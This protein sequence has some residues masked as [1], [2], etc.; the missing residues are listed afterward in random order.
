MKS[1]ERKEQLA[2]LT[3]E[4]CKN[5]SILTC[6]TDGVLVVNRQ[7]QVVLSNA[8]AARIF[9]V[10]SAVFLPADVQDIIKNPTLLQFHDEIAA[11]DDDR[12][13]RTREFSLDRGTYIVNASAVSDPCREN[14]GV[15]LVFRDI[16]AL[17]KPHI[18]RTMFVSMAAKQV[19][20]LLDKIEKDTSL[21]AEK[22]PPQ[23]S[24][25]AG[26]L[27]NLKVETAAL[28]RMFDQ[29][30]H[31]VDMESNR[32]TLKR[33]SISVKNILE[34]SLEATA[35]LARR[36]QVSMSL[37]FCESLTT[38]RILADPDS[39][40][41]VF[42]NILHNAVS[43]NRTGG[44]VRI[45]VKDSGLFIC[46]SIKD[47]GIGMTDEER[48]KIFDVFYRAQND[49]TR[50]IPGAGLGLSLV[51]HLVD[52]HQGIITCRSK[53]GVGTEFNVKFPKA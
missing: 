25:E 1:T 39:L 34:Q 6:M 7:R 15:V 14:L 35:D 5:K 36:Q 21:L 48:E 38:D 23:F 8:A 28:G 31:L 13:I 53:P 51:K 33:G 20:R 49:T 46:I 3:F 29:L 42:L 37:G 9:D 18:A 45:D 2:E 43:Y 44:T 50:H 12:I 27:E 32:Y 22:L 10:L 30:S 24:R 40:E 19:F 52:M 11:C 4:R 47:T 26:N 16:T 17:K 41:R